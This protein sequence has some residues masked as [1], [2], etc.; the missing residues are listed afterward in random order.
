MVTHLRIAV[1]G[2]VQEI[3]QIVGEA[4]SPVFTVS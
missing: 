4:Q 3:L 2:G 1:P